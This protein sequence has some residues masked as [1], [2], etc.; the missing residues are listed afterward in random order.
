LGV[1]SIE[2]HFHS[3]EDQRIPV[4]QNRFR[5][6][7]TDNQFIAREFCSPLKKEGTP[8]GCRV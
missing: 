8:T 5:M 6:H 4:L 2:K 7:F 1:F 3:I